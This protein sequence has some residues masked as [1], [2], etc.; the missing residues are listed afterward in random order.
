MKQSVKWL[1]LFFLGLSSFLAWPAVAGALPVASCFWTGPFTQKNPETN[2]AY[3]GTEI[4]YW[5]A[6]FQMPAG[7]KLYLKGK[8]PY[9]RYASFNAYNLNGASTDSLSDRRIRPDRGSVNTTIPG[10]NRLAKKRN[11]T[12]RVL[13]SARPAGGTPNTLYAESFPGTYQDILYR[14]YVPDRGKSLSG[15]VPLPRPELHLGGKVLRGQE[16]CTALQ[17]SHNY[18]GNKM[19]PTLYNTLVNWPGKDPLTNPA[20]ATFS[21]QK[22]FNMPNV[23]A[24]YKTRP[25]QEAA[26]AANPTYEGTQYNNNDARYMTGSFAWNFG[27]ILVLRGRLPLVPTTL[28]GNKYTGAGELTLWDVCVIESLVTTRTYSCLFDQQI[29]TRGKKRYYTIVVS[30]ADKRPKNATRK[31]G[32]AW[33]RANP[34][35]DGAGR[36]NVGQLLSRNVL[37]QKFLF[38]S[39]AVTTPWNAAE[40]LRGYYPRGTYMSRAAFEKRGC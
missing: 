17:S 38:S 21:W 22:Y 2:V 29:P 27:E 4:T 32:V 10:K 15:G 34:A 25:E 1:A 36:D 28:A 39:W 23:I 16:M 26:W 12:I 13:P 14:V 19:D 33:L 18:T 40:K 24:S 20:E 35:G 3:P 11:Y 6:K 31:C 30:L 37:P 9:A 8:F 7:G 5:G